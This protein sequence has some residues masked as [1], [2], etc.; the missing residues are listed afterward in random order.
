MPDQKPRKMDE[1]IEQMT[2]EWDDE[3]PFE[4]DDILERFGD[5][6]NA[7]EECYNTL[8]DIKSPEQIYGEKKEAVQ[9]EINELWSSISNEMGV[10]EQRST[11]LERIVWLT[12]FQQQL[13]LTYRKNKDIWNTA[14][15]KF[16]ESHLEALF[17]RV[18]PLFSEEV[19]RNALARIH[20]RD[21]EG[22]TR[23]S[24]NVTGRDIVQ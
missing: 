23:H 20:Q 7:T 11:V 16:L 24:T 18:Y 13:E 1:T 22:A 10:E 14:H 9:N 3:V 19:V 21:G 17:L 12:H 15:V 2:G 8:V 5:I 4:T 6:A